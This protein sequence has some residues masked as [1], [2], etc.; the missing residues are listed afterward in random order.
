MEGHS[1]AKAVL[2]VG[3]DLHLHA[4]DQSFGVNHEYMAGGGPAE[5][6]SRGARGARGAFAESIE[7]ARIAGRLLMCGSVKENPCVKRV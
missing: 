1:C 7:S 6:P 4:E 3:L 5:S 2:M